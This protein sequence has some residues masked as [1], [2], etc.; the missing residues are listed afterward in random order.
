[1]SSRNRTVTV[2]GG[3]V[4]ATALA[5]AAAFAAVGTPPASSGMADMPA[6]MAELDAIAI[7]EMQSMMSE[8]A[9]IGEMHRH[10]TEQGHDIGQMHRDVTRSGM[11]PGA[12][13]RNMVTGR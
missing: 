11:N 9:S 13:H 7:A 8:G 4:L 3:A 5:G 2:I 12:M 6:H 10:M 1:M